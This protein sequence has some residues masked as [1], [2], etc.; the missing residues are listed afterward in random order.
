[1]HQLYRLRH[2]LATPAHRGR[3]DRRSG[4]KTGASPKALGKPAPAACWPQC[5]S[6]YYG[7]AA[8]AR[9]RA[10]L[11]S[12]APCAPRPQ[13]YG[14]MC[15]ND[16]TVWTPRPPVRGKV[17][18]PSRPIRSMATRHDI[19]L[20]RPTH[21]ST[22]SPRARTCCRVKRECHKKPFPRPAMNTTSIRLNPCQI[23]TYA[24]PPP[25]FPC[26]SVVVRPPQ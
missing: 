4:K 3:R 20:A 15:Q 25:L 10:L 9:L 23:A 1:M 14:V 6:R 8:R 7:V 2:T 5:G 12:W 18:R 17:M 19:S 11:G 16:V 26:R 24:P 13:W 21:A 22:R